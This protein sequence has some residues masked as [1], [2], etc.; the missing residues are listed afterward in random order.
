MVNA[1]VLPSYLA[2]PNNFWLMLDVGMF[3]YHLVFT[4]FEHFFFVVGAQAVRQIYL[5]TI[6]SRPKLE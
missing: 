5:T 3:H 2:K 1:K 6:G 4:Q